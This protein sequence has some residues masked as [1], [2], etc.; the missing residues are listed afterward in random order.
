MRES[1]QS[2]G[3]LQQLQESVD[4]DTGPATAAAEARDVSDLL[5][6]L[7]R[8]TG[9]RQLRAL[10]AK[11]ATLLAALRTIF[12]HGM[13][14]APSCASRVLEVVDALL[15]DAASRPRV[16]RGCGPADMAL[17]WLAAASQAADASQGTA[18]ALRLFWRLAEVAEARRALAEQREA[19]RRMLLWASCR[20]PVELSTLHHASLAWRAAAEHLMALVTGGEGP[21][22]CLAAVMA[23]SETALQELSK[24]ARVAGD[25]AAAEL[26][27]M[28]R[29]RMRFEELASAALSALF[30]LRRLGAGGDEVTLSRVEAVSRMALPLPGAGRWAS[31][32]LETFN[33]PLP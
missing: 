25:E 7:L 31:K 11:E 18:A 30:A 5:A 6:A 24:P 23:I 26:A 2:T 21:G 8:H 1:H 12:E 3:E 28:K 20:S 17:Q 27:E 19:W 9:N 10:F 32:I 14:A 15:R 4:L 33:A 13:S 22:Q 16:H 29:H